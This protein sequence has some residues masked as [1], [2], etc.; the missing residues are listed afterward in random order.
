MT[1]GEDAE[2][3]EESSPNAKEEDCHNDGYFPSRDVLA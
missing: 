1:F 3:V 2:E